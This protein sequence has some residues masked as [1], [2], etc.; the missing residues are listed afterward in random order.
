MIHDTNGDTISLDEQQLGHHQE[1]T[2]LGADGMTYP[3]GFFTYSYNA[4][5][6]SGIGGLLITDNTGIPLEFVITNAVKSTHP[7]RLLYGKKL[8]S[9]MAINL[10]ATKLLQDVATKPRVI[11]VKEDWLLAICKL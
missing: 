4:S 10:C 7:Q 8:K 9:Y 3:V 11:F 5:N 1:R 6:G 2:M